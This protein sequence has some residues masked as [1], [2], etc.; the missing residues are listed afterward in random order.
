MQQNQCL[1]SYLEFYQALNLLL[2]QPELDNLKKSAHK[3]KSLN[4]QFEL[5]DLQTSLSEL[6]SIGEGYENEKTLSTRVLALTKEAIDEL[7]K[8]SIQSSVQ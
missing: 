4:V 3:I 2:V 6:I 8:M 7:K 5:N 1:E